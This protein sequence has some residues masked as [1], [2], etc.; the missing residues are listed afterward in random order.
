MSDEG[1]LERE[2]YKIL[3]TVNEF[4]ARLLT[5]KG[6]GVTLSLASLG[7]GFQYSHYG[8]FLVAALGGLA[9]WV[10]EAAM[11][12]HQMR[13][14][15][16]LRDIEV[17]EHGLAAARSPSQPSSP[18]I[19]WAWSQAPDVLSG[20][21]PTLPERPEPR[22]AESSRWVWLFPHVVFPHVLSVI[23]GVSLVLLARWGCLG[24]MRW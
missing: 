7:L 6:W 19:D 3:D 15:V 8:L 21:V 5:V 13:H 14:Y 1:S 17:I 12:R 4:D 23:A 20:R 9:F 10:I 22:R 18:K 11:K 16:R 2:Y 24:E